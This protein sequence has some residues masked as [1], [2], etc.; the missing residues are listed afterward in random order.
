MIPKF[1]GNATPLSQPGLTGVSNRL[2]CQPAEIWAVL[3]V[4]TAGCGFLAD[5]RPQILFERHVFSARTDGRFD[6][7][8]SDISNPEPGG[9]GAAGAHQYDRLNKAVGKDEQAAVQSASWG[10][11]QIMG[12]NAH[13]VG[14]ADVSAMITAMVESE[15]NQLLAMAQ[16]L[17]DNG[18]DTDLQ[19]HNWRSFA[20]GYNG[21]TFERN[22]YDT[23]L[24]AA[25]ARYRIL[26]PDLKVRTAQVFL[27]YLDFS[28]GGIDG[29]MGS[30]TRSALQQF[31][32][33][34]GLT[35]SGV[36]D[37]AVVDLLKTEVAKLPR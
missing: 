37:D 14:F 7:E 22:N 29:V 19:S 20:R 27:A 31:Q 6:A 9:Y 24:A 18:L 28:P 35:A 16:F 12:F 23:R 30:R 15:D 3:S 34:H 32:Q 36:V 33:R 4:E 25:F 13:T 11:G 10:I 21:T 26:L 2:G 17:E 8:A 1:V 5:R